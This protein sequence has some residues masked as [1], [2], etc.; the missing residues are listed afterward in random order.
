LPAAAGSVLQADFVIWYYNGLSAS[1][2]EVPGVSIGDIA[3]FGNHLITVVP[4][5]ISSCNITGIP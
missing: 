4:A 1:Y 2:P 3:D 5:D